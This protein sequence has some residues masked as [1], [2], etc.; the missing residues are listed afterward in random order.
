M[1]LLERLSNRF[2]SH[3]FNVLTQGSWRKAHNQGPSEQ[4]PAPDGRRPFG[5]IRDAVVKVLDSEPLGLRASDIH[6]RVELLGER[7]PRGSV[8]SILAGRCR[9]KGRLFVRIGRGR[10][11]LAG[12]RT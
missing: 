6:A 3:L 11:R 7:V 5:S 1:D 8:K 10:Y 12:T 9:G 2:T 4:G